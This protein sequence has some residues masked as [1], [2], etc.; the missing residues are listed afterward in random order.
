MK[1]RNFI[2]TAIGFFLAPTKLLTGARA[3]EWHRTAAQSI[4]PI[5][6]DPIGTMRFYVHPDGSLPRGWALANGVDNREGVGGTGFDVDGMILDE[7]RPITAIER[8]W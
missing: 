3:T 5:D 4:G 6:S 7:H 1:R 2:A 8:L